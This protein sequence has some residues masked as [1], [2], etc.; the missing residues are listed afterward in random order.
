M[1]ADKTERN[2]LVGMVICVIIIVI[3][4][5]SVSHKIRTKG[6]KNIVNEVWEG[7]E[8]K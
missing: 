5:M 7:K 8:S 3:A 2:L 4:V 1:N 6:L